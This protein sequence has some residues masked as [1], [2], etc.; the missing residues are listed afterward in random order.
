MP[1]PKVERMRKRKRNW[2][3][4]AWRYRKDVEKDDAFWVRTIRD[5]LAAVRRRIKI[6]VAAA[7]EARRE[8]RDATSRG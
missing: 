6:Q 8:V 1:Q 2:G 3:E 5:K 4:G 7:D